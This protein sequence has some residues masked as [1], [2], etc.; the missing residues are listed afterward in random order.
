[1]LSTE[2]VATTS[3]RSVNLIALPTRL[4]RTWR[5]RPASPIKRSGTSGA[6]RQASSRPLAWA[7]RRQGLQAFRRGRRAGRTGRRSRLSLPAS[8]L[9]KSR[10]SLMTV[11]SES[12]ELLTRPRYSRWRGESSVS[13]ASSVMPMMP[14]IGRANLV[15]HVG[16]KLALGPAGGLGGLGSGGHE[17]LAFAK[18]GGLPGELA[19][20]QSEIGR[21]FPHP[22]LD[23]GV[24]RLELGILA[25]SSRILSHDWRQARTSTI[26]SK[27]T[28]AECSSHRQGL[29][30]STP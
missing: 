6:I 18:L 9:E 14:F 1:M 28:Q 16:E 4:T 13:R 7:R 2:T 23:P 26:S 8:I 19:V 27:T 25:A 30:V 15:A 5:S 10:M 22:L 12:A 24:G 20:G 17:R 29:A 11:S 21:P 3:P